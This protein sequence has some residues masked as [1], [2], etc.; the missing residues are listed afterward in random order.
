MNGPGSHASWWD[1]LAAVC[2]VPLRSAPRW[3]AVG[4]L[5]LVLVVGRCGIS[6]AVALQVAAG[7]LLGGLLVRVRVPADDV[8]PLWMLP[9]TVACMHV[10]LPEHVVADEAD[11]RPRVLCATDPR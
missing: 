7:A 3:W 4:L 10:L 2:A 6:S 1:D 8:R 11:G 5:A 9:F